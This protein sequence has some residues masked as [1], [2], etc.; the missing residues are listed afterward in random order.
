MVHIN[1]IYKSMEYSFKKSLGKGA[2]YLIIFILPVV[3]DKMILNYPEWAQLSL[4][5][6]LVMVVNYLKVEVAP[7]LG[8][9]L[10]VIK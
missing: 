1:S 3:A 5:G 10:G 6:V 9:K 8:R 4:G 7:K 2:K